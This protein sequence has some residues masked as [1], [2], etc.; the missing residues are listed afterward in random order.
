ML[1]QYSPVATKFGF[2]PDW[3]QFSGLMQKET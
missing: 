2:V 3:W 1:N